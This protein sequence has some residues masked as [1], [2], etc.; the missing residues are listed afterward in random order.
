MLYDHQTKAGNQGDV[1]KHVA[2]LAALDRTLAHHEGIHFRFADTF[3]GY[4]QSRLLK[5]GEW[6]SG[7]GALAV[8][9]KSNKLASN[10]H[11]ALW[12]D[13]YFGRRP[14]LL[15]SDYPG[16]S[17]IASDICCR[18]KKRAVMSLWDISPP[19]VADLMETYAG[20]G[21]SVITEPARHTAEAVQ[22]ADFLFIDPPGLRSPSHPEYPSWNSIR[23]FLANRPKNQSLLLWLPVK[24]VTSRKLDG[25]L[26]PIKPPGEDD[27]SWS[28]RDD[29]VALGCGAMRVRWSTGGRTIGCHLIHF[30]AD[31]AAIALRASVEH[32]VGVAGWQDTLE[33]GVPAIALVRPTPPIEPNLLG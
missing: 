26:K 32:V 14:Q 15:G 22:Q 10:A 8:P 30:L 19:A 13:W 11:T 29:A 25:E 9:D 21:H 12:R 4:A 16:S 2:L 23:E 27:P 3:A 7:I 33:T 1:V 28:A 18:H 20:L 5:G 6:T 24:A 17:L 31:D